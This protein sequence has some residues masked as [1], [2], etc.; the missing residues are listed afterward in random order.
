MQILEEVA[1]TLQKCMAGIYSIKITLA[2]RK[3]EASVYLWGTIFHF[4]Y[5]KVGM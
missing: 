4:M 1:E 2:D 5:A 3:N